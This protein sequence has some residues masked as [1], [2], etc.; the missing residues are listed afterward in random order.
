MDLCT[1]GEQRFRM[2]WPPVTERTGIWMGGMVCVPLLGVDVAAREAIVQA[3][4]KTDIP[5]ELSLSC[6]VAGTVTQY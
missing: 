1:G 4:D 3:P 5:H 6:S 2:L